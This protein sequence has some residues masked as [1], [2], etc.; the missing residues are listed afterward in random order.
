MRAASGRVR[1][2][3]STKVGPSPAAEMRSAVPN[4]FQESASNRDTCQSPDLPIS[5]RE[6]RKG[7]ANWLARNYPVVNLSLR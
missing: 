1:D 2:N 6:K 7:R 5:Y 4:R 3:F